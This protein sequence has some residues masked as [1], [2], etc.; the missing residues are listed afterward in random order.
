[1]KSIDAHHFATGINQYLQDLQSETIVLTKSSKP[2]AIVRGL[3]YDEEQL[4]LVNSH[5]FW[6]MIQQRRREPTIPW[7][8]AKRRLESLE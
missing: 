5:E 4:Q 8:V 3:D 6:A 7:Q 2:C 1:M